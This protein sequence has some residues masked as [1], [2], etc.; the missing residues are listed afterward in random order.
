MSNNNK[1]SLSADLGIMR[2]MTSRGA[3]PL[4][5][6][7]VL[8]LMRATNAEDNHLDVGVFHGI[9]ALE[10][11]YANSGAVP[12]DLEQALLA[13]GSQLRLTA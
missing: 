9:R 13:V 8:G 4:A 1:G 6:A 7:T 3:T 10:A 12:T 5:A 2:I 11:Y